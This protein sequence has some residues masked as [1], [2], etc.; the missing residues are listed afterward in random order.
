LFAAHRPTGSSVR[1]ERNAA[2]LG[3]GPLDLDRRGV[4][5]LELAVVAAFDE[6]VADLGSFDHSWVASEGAD[7]VRAVGYLSA[8]LSM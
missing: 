2:D 5:V 8:G 1:V 3:H 6:F 4:G 7:G